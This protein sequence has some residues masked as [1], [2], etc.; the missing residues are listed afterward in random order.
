MSPHPI[1]A[2]SVEEIQQAVKSEV[3]AVGSLRRGQAERSALLEALGA[4]WTQG[5][6]VAW[7]RQFS[8]GGRRVAL[9]TYP[10]QRE[11]HWIEAKA[12][13]SHLAAADPLA[14][15]FYRVDWPE[16]PRAAGSPP[17]AGAGSWLVLADR[18]GVGESV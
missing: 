15:W 4:L 6:P 3:A 5:Y 18:G 9:P 12:A 11:R 7:E 14:D 17:Q 8:A 2:A 16:L 13:G 10:W 1:L